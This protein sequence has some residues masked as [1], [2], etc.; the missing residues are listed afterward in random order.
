MAV[1]FLKVQ[2]A[3]NDFILIDGRVLPGAKLSPEAVVQLCDRH[4]GIGA[5]GVLLL[6]GVQDGW[7]R[8]RIYNAD[9]SIAQMCGNGLRCFAMVMKDHFG[10][11]ESPLLVR[12]DAGD[13]LC[14]IDGGQGEARVTIEMG[15]VEAFS[16]GPLQ[17]PMV[18]QEVTVMG[19]SVAY[20]G[21]ST[22]NP[23]AVVISGRTL[24]EVRRLGPLMSVHPVFPEGA[25][26]EFLTVRGPRELEV[27]VCERG[28]GFTLACGTGAV[29]ATAAAVA[30]GHCPSDQW[31]SVTLPG[32]ILD[33]RVADD[34][35]ASS[36]A[37]PAREVFSGTIEIP[38]S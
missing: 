17:L 13:K 28:V 14:V 4:F 38:E 11:S 15:P 22:G 35:S 21:A 33:V 32:G 24:D 2:G 36:L 23:H 29:A 3:G 37:G 30:V 34:L 5:D 1:T 10:W 18:A 6:V 12:T 9:G 25:N 16:G 20:Y 19:E 31:I 27:V 8:M 7:P 26:I